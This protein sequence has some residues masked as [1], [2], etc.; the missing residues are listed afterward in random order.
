MEGEV[1][2]KR[3]REA[4]IA[5][6]MIKRCLVFCAAIFV[7]SVVVFCLARYAPGDP[8]Q[9]FYGSDAQ[10]M[11]EAELEAAR[12]RLGLDGPVWIQYV[13]WVE[14]AVQGDFGISLQYKMPAM[15]VIAPLIGNT[16]IL[17]AAGY[18]LVFLLSVLLAVV[19]ARF[20]DSWLDRLICKIGTIMYYIPPFWFGVVLIMIFSIGLG[21][22]PSSGAYDP[23]MEDSI[24]N[25]ISHMILPLIVIVASHLW[26]YTC[27]FRNKLLDEVRKDYVLLAKS[28]GLGKNRILW[29]HCLRNIAPTIISIMAIS[30][31][32]VLSGTYIA[33]SVFNYAGIGSLGVSSAKYHDYNLLMLVVLITGVLVIASSLIAQSVNEVIDPRMKMG[34]ESAWKKR[35]VSRGCLR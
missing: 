14:H 2:V 22:L 33:E 1:R 12:S 6:N 10:T 13:R 16:L 30:V 4:E 34:E 3:K 8:V 31:P 28:N 18:I 23:G 21:W 35:R 11:S 15:E 19:C 5:V 9:T 24:G 26:Y 25:R 17:G 7:L 20:E 27:M 32:H 29:G